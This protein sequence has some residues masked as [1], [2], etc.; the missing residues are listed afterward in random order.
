MSNSALCYEDLLETVTCNLCGSSNYEVI[1]PPRY[2]AAAPN[3]IANIFRSSGDEILM[4][5]LVRC[6]TC[7]LQYLN[8][9]LR[10]DLV[11]DSYSV[12]SDEAFVSQVAARE[13]TFA[14]SLDIIEKGAPQ[15][16]RVLDVGTARG[17]FL[18]GGKQSG[19]GG[20]GCELN[21]R[22]CEL[23]GRGSGISIY[24]GK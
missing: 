2:E 23:G 12:G 6:Q 14:K 21:E 20:S 19:W 17:S 22:L 11:V 10:Q 5:Q 24:A 16:G 13:R 15:R 18:G 8:P 7:G 4:D 1:Y 3:E 9:R